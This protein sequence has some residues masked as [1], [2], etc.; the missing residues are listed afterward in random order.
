MW[1]S[2]KL[3]KGI[4][5][6][7]HPAATINKSQPLQT[8]MARS[9]RIAADIETRQT[10]WIVDKNGEHFEMDPIQVCAYYRKK[11]AKNVKSVTID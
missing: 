3:H 7:P 4:H 5:K 6:G 2:V 9:Y 10:V 11:Y 1:Q 8:I